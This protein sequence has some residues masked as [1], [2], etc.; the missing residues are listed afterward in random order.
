MSRLILLKVN[1]IVNVIIIF[2]LGSTSA[3]DCEACPP[4]KYSSPEE[5]NGVCLPCDPPKY[6]TDSETCQFCSEGMYLSTSEN[7]SH[8]AK[9]LPGKSS[10]EGFEKHNYTLNFK[11]C[12]KLL[13]I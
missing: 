4:G 11:D 3:E 12:S 6:T 5:T 8:C 13:K 10:R 2:I 7:G 1:V 9:C